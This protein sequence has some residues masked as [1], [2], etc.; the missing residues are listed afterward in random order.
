MLPRRSELEAIPQIEIAAFMEPAD[1]VG[2][3]YYDV[4]F[5]ENRVKIG[6]GDVTGHGLE[7]GVLMLMVQ[8]VARALQEKGDKDPVAFLD[9]LNRAV[10]KNIAR[11]RSDKHLTL[12]F[13]D[14]EDGNVTLSGQH[15][16]V[17][18]VRSSGRRRMDR[19][20]RSGLPRRA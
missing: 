10:Y 11:T 5:D 17:L 14:Y 1:E 12:A 3:D 16:E 15:E 18:I 20:D 6:I 13:V 2:G 4:L 19:H 9:V 7:S 8:S